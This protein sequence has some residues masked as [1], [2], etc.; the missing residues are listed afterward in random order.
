MKTFLIFVWLAIPM[1][2][3]ILFATAGVWFAGLLIVLFI[4]ALPSAIWAKAQQV[5]AAQ[6]INKR[7]R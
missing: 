1:A 5:K 3:I 7:L 2:I 4:W 6:K